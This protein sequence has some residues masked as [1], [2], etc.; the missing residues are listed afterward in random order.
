MENGFLNL[1]KNKKGDDYVLLEAHMF[2]VFLGVTLDSAFRFDS[3]VSCV[4]GNQLSP[5][6][7]SGKG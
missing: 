2:Q 3:Q 4:K 5:T 1:N 6:K 7:T